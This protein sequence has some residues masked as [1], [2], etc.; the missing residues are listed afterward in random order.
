MKTVQHID[1]ELSKYRNEL[2]TLYKAQNDLFKELHRGGVTE[3]D[4]KA[5]QR[6][7]D[8][9]FKTT[10][11]RIERF[12]NLRLYREQTTDE[13]ITIELER[14]R[15]EYKKRKKA[16]TKRAIEDLNFLTA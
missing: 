7:L 9:S 2:A 12:T 11:S 14:L 6:V 13:G 16:A 5:K 3:A 4:Y 1:A 8:L 15:A 10:R